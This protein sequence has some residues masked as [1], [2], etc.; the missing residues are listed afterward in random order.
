MLKHCSSTAG[1]GPS[2]V[3]VRKRPQ[4]SLNITPLQN[5][6]TEKGERNIHPIRSHP[7][8]VRG[9]KKKKGGVFL[10][11][12][13]VC[14][15]LIAFLIHFVAPGCVVLAVRAAGGAL[16]VCKLDDMAIV[17]VWAYM[18]APVARRI[19]PV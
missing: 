11:T 5:R 3:G 15:C 12:V 14:V 10:D 8:L 18:E 17:R 13:C 9:K 16:C 19:Q 4:P 1:P 2:P 6:K 7:K